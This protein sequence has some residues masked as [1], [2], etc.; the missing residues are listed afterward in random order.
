M[1]ATT[2][3]HADKPEAVGLSAQ[4]LD[5]LTDALTS[6]IDRK[7]IPGAVALIARRGRIAYLQALGLRDPGT[8]S[9]MREDAI[10][11]IY[12][13]TKPLVSVAAMMLVEEGRI[14]L[15]D[16]VSK[17]LPAFAKMQVSVAKPDS[18]T[19]RPAHEMVP[20]SP[21]PTVYDLL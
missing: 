15:S 20:A 6:A 11:R 17:Y 2:S 4:R 5:A 21:A 7:L 13:M 18:A 19:G 8:A 10:F 14:V 9:P 3:L 12:S 16:P 1:D